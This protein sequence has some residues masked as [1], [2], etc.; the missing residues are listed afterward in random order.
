MAPK[1][2]T[3]TG[4]VKV[5]VKYWPEDLSKIAVWNFRDKTYV[6]IPCISRQYAAGLSEHHHQILTKY[7]KNLGLKFST[8]EERCAAKE[9]LREKIDSLVNDRLIGTRRRAQRLQPHPL[10][11]VQGADVA[12]NATS[13]V[14]SIDTYST[15]TRGE[16]E[17]ESRPKYSPRGKAR[18]T[19]PA[20]A[21]PSAPPPL[22]QEP[23][24]TDIFAGFDRQALL[25]QFRQGGAE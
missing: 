3:T 24:E 6:E 16:V 9:R 13:N 12:P 4:S 18:S 14:V 7:A 11:D 21:K 1:R 25:N 2:G 15:R 8:E 20:K 22:P 23:L 10:A 5:K 19:A 17:A